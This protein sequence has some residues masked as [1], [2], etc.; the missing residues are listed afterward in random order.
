MGVFYY[1]LIRQRNASLSV[2]Q[3]IRPETLAEIGSE[4]YQRQPLLSPWSR[5]NFETATQLSAT[6]L[7]NVLF[8]NGRI[9]ALRE[10]RL[11]GT[12]SSSKINVWSHTTVLMMVN[13]V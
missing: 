11:Q 1:V 10:S 4:N 9:T 5:D 7:C 8:S 13:M 6:S 2:A 3:V 12:Y